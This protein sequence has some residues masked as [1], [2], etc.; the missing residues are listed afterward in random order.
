MTS[1]KV[2]Q[3]LLQSC[4]MLIP[5]PTSPCPCGSDLQYAECCGPLHDGARQA[6]TAKALMRARYSAFVTRNETFLLDSWHSSTRPDHV[7][8]ANEVPPDWRGLSVLNTQ[9]GGEHDDDGQVEFIARFEI[10]GKPG[11]LHETSE[12]RREQGQ[13]RYLDGR[14]NKGQPLRREKT[15]RND[16]CPCGSGKKYKK[17]CGR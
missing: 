3:T 11:Q 4:A 17:C 8:E 16:P 1:C 10:D 2:A 7:F 13:W 9:R 14:T 15:G 5:G 6:A 12:F